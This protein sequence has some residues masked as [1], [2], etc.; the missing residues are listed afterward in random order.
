MSKI[1]WINACVREG[2][3]TKELAECVLS[4][5]SGQVQELKLYETELLPL[6]M[7]GL[8]ARARAGAA[9][10]FSDDRF[11]LA[12]QF[13]QADT[14]VVAA[15]YWDLMFPAVVKSY[16][17]AI[18]VSGLTFVYGE[19]GIPMGLCK[20]KQ[21][22]YVTTAGGPIVRN[23]GYEYVAALARAFYGIEQVRCVCAQGLDIRGA[24][25]SQIMEAAKREITLEN[26]QK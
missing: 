10:D 4:K 8:E 2:S 19:T 22:I 24:D 25:V 14:I 13:A 18:T 5:L 1:L 20:A 3:R 17:E 16:F 23:F 26:D 7:E 21:L 12:R 15:P 6:D 9:K 11:A